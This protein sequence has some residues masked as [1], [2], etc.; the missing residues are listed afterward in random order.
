[1]KSYNTTGN[2]SH[3]FSSEPDLKQDASSEYGMVDFICMGNSTVMSANREIQNEKKN[4][5]HSGIQTRDL[6]HTKRTR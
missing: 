3:I 6:L 2:D 4:L 5:A 1:M